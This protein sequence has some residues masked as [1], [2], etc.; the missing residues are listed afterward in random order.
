MKLDIYFYKIMNIY[1]HWLCYACLLIIIIIY[2]DSLLTVCVCVCVCI[3]IYTHTH[4][5]TH[6][7]IFLLTK[8]NLLKVYTEIMK[9]LIYY[10]SIVNIYISID[11]WSAFLL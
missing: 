8:E 3:Y 11:Q 2:C 5:H 1:S 4:T 6:T 10:D 9:L 7:H